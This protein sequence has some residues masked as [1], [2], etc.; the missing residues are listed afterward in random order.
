VNNLVQVVKI[1][2][3]DQEDTCF[4]CDVVDGLL[5]IQKVGQGEKKL[6]VLMVIQSGLKESL[7][8][9]PEVC[10]LVCGTW[11]QYNN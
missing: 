2:G 8:R 6:T 7:R 4:D 3:Q 11:F 5:E 10:V 1:N 9:V